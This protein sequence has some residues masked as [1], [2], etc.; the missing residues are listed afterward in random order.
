MTAFKWAIVINANSCYVLDAE[1]S[2]H[3]MDVLMTSAITVKSVYA[4]I[5]GGQLTVQLAV[6]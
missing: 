4:T 3:V 6:K 2:N 5:L 1:K